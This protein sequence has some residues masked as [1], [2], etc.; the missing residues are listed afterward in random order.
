[1]RAVDLEVYIDGSKIETLFIESFRM[2]K[3][4]NEHGF[5]E[6]TVSIPTGTEESCINIAASGA[7]AEI[8]AVQ[9]DRSTSTIF[10]GIVY[11]MNVTCD[12]HE[13]KM[14]LILKA[15]TYAMDAKERTRTFQNAGTTYEQLVNH[16]NSTHGAKCKFRRLNSSTINDMKVQ[17]KETDWQFVLRLASMLKQS[18]LYEYT[19]TGIWYYIGL[20]TGQSGKKMSFDSYAMRKM[21]NDI[22]LKKKRGLSELTDADAFSY[23][24]TSREVYQLGEC[25]EFHGDKMYVYQVTSY[26]NKEEVI[27][28]YILRTEN[29]FLQPRIYQEKL[30]GASMNGA[31]AGVT[32][33]QVKVTLD[34]DGG[35]S[36]CGSRLFPYS[37]VYSSSSGTGWYCMP[38]NGDSI[39]LYC[40]TAD[41]KDAYV[42]SSVHLDSSSGSKNQRSDPNTKSIRSV[43]DKEVSFGETALTLTNNNGM[44][45]VLDDK[46][47]ITIESD[48]K[49]TVEAKED[50]AITGSQKIKVKADE[51]LELIQG[52]SKIRQ[53]SNNI[54]IE[55]AIL[56]QQN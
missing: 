14:K 18:I 10:T 33:D 41:E 56:K 34:V 11:D 22:Q 2:E 27:N 48:K 28:D 17:Y 44:K 38:E 15:G 26:W 13:P 40:P 5:A 47:G 52:N 7:F 31:I 12:F 19:R 8:K 43:H 4:I 54:Y 30:I 32:K 3:H 35:N 50:I 6:L 51:K 1:M 25:V 16:V 39:R 53:E 21:V 45:I 37:T 20:D 9:E 42:L 46:E 36:L 24:V 49:V 23:V 55:G 29:A